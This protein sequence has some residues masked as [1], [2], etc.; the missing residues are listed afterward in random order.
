MKESKFA[1]L[2][3][4]GLIGFFLGDVVWK[5]RWHVVYSLLVVCAYLIGRHHELI[6]KLLIGIVEGM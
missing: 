1:H 3:L 6:K 4:G 5:R 2:L